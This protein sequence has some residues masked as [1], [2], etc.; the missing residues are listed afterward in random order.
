MNNLSLIKVAI[1]PK[2]MAGSGAQT[3]NGYIHVSAIIGMRDNGSN[4]Q[5]YLKPEYES[6]FNKQIFGS[7]T[8]I[9][10]I[11]VEAKDIV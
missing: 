11:T 7:N 3:V 6:V 4:L 8:V 9:D 5:V 2:Q 10:R 1:H